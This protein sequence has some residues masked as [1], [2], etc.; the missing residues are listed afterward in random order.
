MAVINHKLDLVVRLFDASTGRPVDEKN[1]SFKRNDVPFRLTEKGG[2]VFF[3]INAGRENFELS[4]DIY[5]FEAKRIL[6]DYGELDERL[7]EKL[8]WLLPKNALS[9]EGTLKGITSLCAVR[10]VTP[11]CFVN[12]YDARKNV[13][14]LFNPHKLVMAYHEY[15]IL[16]SERKFF[17]PIFLKNEDGIETV[18]PAAPLKRTPG[19]NDP[20]E[21][22]IQGDVS[23]DGR[24]VL[25]V[26]DDADRI[27]LL[28]RFVAEG[29]EYFQILEMHEPGAD[30][31]DPKNAYEAERSEETEVK[32][33]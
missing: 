10:L 32:S 20:I 7:P 19:C 30:P 3:L 18:T 2:G 21:K 22:I 12:S 14:T 11:G 17:E 25:R 24:Y 1:C 26:R 15:G 13:V 23:E 9:L 28:V 31:L 5:G 27:E 29:R 8:V 4:L 6:I 16:D 33:D